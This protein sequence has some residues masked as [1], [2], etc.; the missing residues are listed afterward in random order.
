MS[1]LRTLK[2]ALVLIGA[3]LAFA[4]SPAQARDELV[5]GITQY[6]STFNPNIDAMMAKSYLLAMAR[7]PLM[8]YDHDWKLA[9][10]LCTEVPTI[11]NG[12]LKPVDLPDGGKGVDIR[13]TIR[14]GAKWGDG[15]PVTSDDVVFAWE[16]GKHPQSAIDGG[17]YYR[18]VTKIDVED[19][20]NFVVHANRLSGNPLRNR[21][22]RCDSRRSPR[23]RIR[24]HVR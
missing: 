1:R 2:L 19:E 6:P 7:R 15:R 11:E 5:I 24:Q 23:W 9:C 16:L 17:E 13:Y 21:D 14:P 12:R 10:V 4:S 20:R 22:G 18:R 3:A 8:I